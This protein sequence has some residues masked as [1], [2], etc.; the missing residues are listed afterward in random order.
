MYMETQLKLK[1]GRHFGYSPSSR[2]FVQLGS[3]KHIFCPANP[4]K[5]NN[6]WKFIEIAERKS[7]VTKLWIMTPSQPKPWLGAAQLPSATKD[8]YKV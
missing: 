6:L 3:L 8:Q 4:E 2:N 1:L 7:S 5:R